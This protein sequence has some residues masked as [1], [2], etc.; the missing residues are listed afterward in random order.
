M[1]KKVSNSKRTNTIC[2]RAINCSLKKVNY[3]LADECKI[4]F[5]ELT[6]NGSSKLVHIN[7]NTSKG[8]KTGK[9]I[10][11]TTFANIYFQVERMR[12]YSEFDMEFNLTLFKK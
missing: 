9:F 6:S 4:I 11:H 2:I 7:L 10:N 3:Y 1:I 5:V 8:V 12:L